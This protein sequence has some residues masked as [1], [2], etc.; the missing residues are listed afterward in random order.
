M[1]ELKIN[2][3]N[4]QATNSIRFHILVIDSSSSMK[5]RVLDS[6]KTREKVVKKVLKEMAEELKKLPEKDS[7]RVLTVFFDDYI[8]YDEFKEIDEWDQPDYS[9]NGYTHLYKTVCWIKNQLFQINQEWKIEKGKSVIFNVIF[10]SDGQDCSDGHFSMS[11]AIQAVEQMREKLVVSLQFYDIGGEAAPYAREM[12]FEV[13][14]VSNT[15]SSIRDAGKTMSRHLYESSMS[16]IPIEN[17]SKNTLSEGS[18][19]AKEYANAM[20]DAVPGDPLGD[21][22]DLFDYV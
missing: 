11:D 6:N 7:T 22:A 14:E 13:K 12:G 16:G 10:L 15:E 19:A 21:L 5:T 18:V 3:P 4:F 9:S 1:S 17:L 2:N 20:Q 8:R